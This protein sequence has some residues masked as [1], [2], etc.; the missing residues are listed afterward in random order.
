VTRNVSRV[1][2]EGE[3]GGGKSREEKVTS[4]QNP[5]YS[6]GSKGKK[7]TRECDGSRKSKKNT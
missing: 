7:L 6:S 5:A 2:V 3:R 4:S 1:R